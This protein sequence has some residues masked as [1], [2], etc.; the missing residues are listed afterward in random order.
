MRAYPPI[1]LEQLVQEVLERNRTINCTDVYSV[2]NSAG[3]V[4]STEYFNKE[5]FSKDIS[6]YKVVRKGMFAYNPSRINVG[7]LAWLHEMETVVVSP[8]YIVF[9][10][11][12]SKLCHQYLN[13]F[14]HSEIGND[15]IRHLTTGSVR[16]S[17][18]FSALKRIS[19][20]L[21]PIDT[22]RRIAAVL[23][24]AQSLI[25]ARREQIAVL[26]KL[27]K[28]LFV[29]MFGDPMLNPKGWE[30]AALGD[31][32]KVRS[33]K[34][35]YQR[36]QT[37]EG[38]PFLRV[39]DIVS[40]ITGQGE[41]ASLFISNALYDELQNNGLTPK[42][43]DILVTSRGTLGRCYIVKDGDR[44]Y[45]QDGMISWLDNSNQNINVDYLVQ[46]FQSE[47]VIKQ[48]AE[49]SAGS[50]VAY[51]SLGNL[52]AVEIPCPPLSLQDEFSRKIGLINKQKA[53]LTKSLAELES[54][55]KSLTQ[56]AFAGEL[57][58][59]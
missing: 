8:L 36:E 35:I 17:L 38:V 3:F 1:L 9:Q 31:V 43:S 49:K 42:A 58:K 25:A 55:Y 14:M 30:Y 20:P 29:D 47:K 12:D 50:T 10:I 28:D 4:P 57:I 32:C 21:P 39:S 44:F 15:Q 52:Q 54:L 24:K 40:R 2:T 13:L 37:R 11:D 22:Q 46:V 5:V 23:D 16:D 18:K 48:I 19:I 7:S 45:F 26:D 56:R 53:R 34:R 33:S 51:L 59:A 27:S 41:T 6:S